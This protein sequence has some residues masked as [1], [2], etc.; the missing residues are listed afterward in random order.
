MDVLIV[1]R[2]D[3]HGQ[4]IK[5]EGFQLIPFTMD[6]SGKNLFREFFIFLSLLRIYKREKPD[7]V[8]HVALKPVLYGSWAARLCG[9]PFVVNALAGLG[10]VFIDKGVKA[11]LLKKI[12]KLAL[13]SALLPGNVRTIFQNPD[14]LNTFVREGLLSR[15]KALLIKGSGVDTKKFAPAKT[16]GDMPIVVLVSRMLWTK[17]VGDFVNAAK[18]LKERGLR[19]RMVLVGEADS[20]NPASIPDET[21]E[22]WS[23]SLVEWFGYR[24]DVADILK[25]SSIAVLPSYREG[26]PKSLIEAA[27]AGLPI[28]TYDVPGCREIVL[29][30]EN[31]FL[32]PLKDI[33][34]LANAIERL[35]EDSTLRC[36]MGIRSREI[37][38]NE[39][40]EEHVV[41]KTMSLYNEF[42]GDKWAY[43]ERGE[44]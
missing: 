8:H 26:V 44:I 28:V 4:K 24:E 11:L 35:L 32:V 19:V 12:V 10:H 40:A 31:G 25:Q 16:M 38:L 41:E 17:G 3:K 7:L 2:V 6:R 15:G 33:Q 23:A 27:S 9:V 43:R 1:T 36:K 13:K 29:H 20:M 18:I 42:L 34:S 30:G 37:V 22:S 39:F 14:D 5:E 21:L